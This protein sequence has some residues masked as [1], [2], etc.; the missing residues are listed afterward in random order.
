[1]TLNAGAQVIDLGL[2]DTA[3]QE[4]YDRLRPLSY[5]NANVF[6]I[7]YS[8]VSST[9]YENVSAKVC[10]AARLKILTLV[11][12]SGIDAFVGERHGIVILTHIALLMCPLFW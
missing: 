9:S 4:E 1:M 2:W 3:G 7:C 6:L 5:T 11:V 12:G 8:C 10:F